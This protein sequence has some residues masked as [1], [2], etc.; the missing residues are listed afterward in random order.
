MANNY[1]DRHPGSGTTNPHRTGPDWH[2]MPKGMI[3]STPVV[4]CKTVRQEPG[5]LRQIFGLPGKETEVCR[6]IGEKVTKHY[7]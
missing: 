2:P 6:V 1:G 3:E 5:L 4:E 7:R